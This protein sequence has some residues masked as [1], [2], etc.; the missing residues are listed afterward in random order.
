LGEHSPSV[1]QHD[2]HFQRQRSRP[3]ELRPD[4]N[5]TIAWSGGRHSRRGRQPG[6][7]IYNNGVWD[8]QSDQVF[9]DDFGG[10]GTTFNNYGTLRKSGGAGEFANATIFTGG[11][12]FNQLAGAID[13]QNGT[14]GLELAFQGGGTFSGGYVTPTRSG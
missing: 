8:A 4:N 1:W 12:V 13:V 5:G 14:N 11:V 2:E 10:A 7:F 9:N 6:T 3:A